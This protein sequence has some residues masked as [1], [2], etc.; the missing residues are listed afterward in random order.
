MSKLIIYVLCCPEIEAGLFYVK[1]MKDQPRTLKPMT[2][3]ACAA[4]AS[5]AAMRVCD[6]MLPEIAQDFETTNGRAASTITAFAVSYGLFQFIYGP[7]GDRYNKYRLISLATFACTF[8]TLSAAVSPFL[9]WLIFSRAIAGAT[10]AAIVPLSIAWIGDNVSYAERQA[11]LARFLSGPILGLISG[12]FLGGFVADTFG[13]RWCF[14]LLA[15]IYVVIGALLH[16]EITH[17]KPIQSQVVSEPSLTNMP[18]FLTQ[19][20]NVLRVKWARLILVVVFLESLTVFGSVAFIPVHLHTS[21]GLS[22]TASGAIMSVFGLGGLSYTVIAGRLV[23][24]IG[25]RGIVLTGGFL[26]GVA[27]LVFLLA[28][29]WAWAIPASFATGMGFYMLHNTLQTN[30][31]Q[32]APLARGTA[33]A[34]FVAHFFLGQSVGVALGSAVIDRVGALWLFAASAI[35][36]PLIAAGFAFALHYKKRE[37]SRASNIHNTD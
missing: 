27:F 12:Q 1:N 28:N 30:A 21:F 6:S 35:V 11:T 20:A 16:S 32:M 7:L 34:L 13:W 4:F 14:V 2:L 36:S 10:A 22:L 18:A 15:I 25:E 8:G 29:R 37:Y 24:Q 3:L 31:T 23:T 19:F 33:V 17:N 5:V 26:L 9:G